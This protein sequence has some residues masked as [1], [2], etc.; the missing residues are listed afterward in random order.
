[1]GSIGFCPW[2][3]VMRMREI[4]LIGALAQD[5]IDDLV[6]TYRLLVI[7]L[8]VTA[9]GQK[10]PT[11]P[12][13]RP[14]LP[15]QAVR[16][17]PQEYTVADPACQSSSDEYTLVSTW[18]AAW[19]GASV[20]QKNVP[21]RDT[22]T[23]RSLVNTAVARTTF[24]GMEERLC[25]GSLGPSQPC[26]DKNFQEPPWD[27]IT[28]GK[29]LRICKADSQFGRQ[30]YEGVALTSAFY[31]QKARDRY[32]GITK[33]TEAPSPI[34]LSVLPQLADYY[35][36]QN[37]AGQN[38]H[39]KRYLT[40]NLA[41]FPD[42]ETIVVF[43]ESKK[44]A[45]TAQGFFWESGF[46]L[47]H[48]YG[49]HI[50]F[51]R[52]GAAYR[53][54]GLSYHPLQHV[55]RESPISPD[56]S[57]PGIPEETASARSV[58]AD[59]V[60]GP[61]LRNELSSSSSHNLV[62]ESRRSL[63]GSALAEAFADLL[64]YYTEGA[65]SESII[66]LPDIGVSRNVASRYFGDGQPK[67]L[68]DERLKIFF[69]ETKETDPLANVSRFNDVHTVG[70]TLAYAADRMFTR[71]LKG[72]GAYGPD[73]AR[74]I[75]QRYQLTLEWMDRV[76]TTL[77]SLG[78]DAD[79]HKVIDAVSEGFESTIKR[80]L[81]S[82]PLGDVSSPESSREMERDLCLTFE[83]ILPG[84]GSLPFSNTRESCPL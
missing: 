52:H 12:Q 51:E 8:V 50:D 17:A 56:E 44:R 72:Y 28:P 23:K 45:E 63:L 10:D 4:T 13:K 42:A 3:K 83:A 14:I 37:L 20:I 34:A 41:Y 49:H 70:A 11:P 15:I 67:I 76:T 73:D 59:S 6:V 38:V 61:I 36:T 7:V 53:T 21:L 29:D 9:C 54:A 68:T 27:S 62:Y 46:V 26:L 75:D 66:G 22:F 48:E 69:R 16:D 43:P 2:E 77:V 81:A 25:T 82:F 18:V 71:L 80:H 19:Q 64:A 30:T 84:L 57:A 60:E 35:V 40:H 32:L 65:S 5:F 1:M 78:P 79:R 58:T 31:I 24:G 47:A 74:G 33:S 55:L 39:I